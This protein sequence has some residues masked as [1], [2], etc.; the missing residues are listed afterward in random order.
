M[1]RV[2]I[3]IV[4]AKLRPVIMN[5]M[6]NCM[7]QCLGKRNINFEFLKDFVSSI[8][9][10]IKFHEIAD[11]AVDVSIELL[12]IVSTMVVYPAMALNVL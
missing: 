5:S 11:C 12:P 7:I 1:E 3:V 6:F 10:I 8:K 2:A 4:M 9:I